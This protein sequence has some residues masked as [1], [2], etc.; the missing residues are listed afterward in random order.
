[1]QNLKSN[2]GKI[3]THKITKHKIHTLYSCADITINYMNILDDTNIGGMD[4]KK[5]NTVKEEI[6]IEHL[7]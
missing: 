6:E 7:R 4:N 3:Y 2:T 1:M 5:M